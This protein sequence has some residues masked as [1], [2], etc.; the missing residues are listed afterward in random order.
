MKPVFYL[1]LCAACVL[2]MGTTAS[3]AA[4]NGD[5]IKGFTVGEIIQ[6]YNCMDVIYPPEADYNARL[7]PPVFA[8]PTESSR[9]IG[10]QPGFV[11]VVWPLNKVNGFIEIL[12][13][14]G[15]RGWI[16]A[17]DTKPFT[18]PSSTNTPGGCTIRMTASGAIVFQGYSVG[19]T[20]Q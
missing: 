3:F 9:K 17:K 19:S 15:D 8:A 13:I 7:L 6:G 10:T 1:L 20:K 16:A 18:Y 4:S 5:K 2:S 11:Y 12:R 14:N